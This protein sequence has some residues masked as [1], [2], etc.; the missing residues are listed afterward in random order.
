MFKK[1][2]EHWFEN[3]PPIV[4]DIVTRCSL[5]AAPLHNVRTVIVPFFACASV[6]T[7][8]SF[9]GVLRI[10]EGTR[11]FGEVLVSGFGRERCCVGEPCAFGGGFASHRRSV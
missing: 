10:F 2:K 4:N 3:T 1:R 5:V 6:V 11:A 9:E 7:T 8:R